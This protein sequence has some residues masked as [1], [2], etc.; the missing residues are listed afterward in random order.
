MTMRDICNHNGKLLGNKY[1][2]NILL[3]HS[4]DIVIH[5]YGLIIRH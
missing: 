2:F 1:I 5:V 4:G 3:S